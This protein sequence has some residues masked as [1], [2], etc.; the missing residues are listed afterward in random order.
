MAANTSVRSV[1]DA[2]MTPRISLVAVC[3][4]SDCVSV[5]LLS[6]SSWNS[7]AFSMAITAWSANVVTR[8]ISRSVKGTGS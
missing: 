1:G 3:C 5:R 2:A 4:S 6:C 7:R 8:A